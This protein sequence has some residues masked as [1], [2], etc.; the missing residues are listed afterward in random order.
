[1]P[2]IQACTAAALRVVSARRASY[3]GIIARPKMTRPCRPTG[4]C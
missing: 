2:S 3:R 1:L 4:P